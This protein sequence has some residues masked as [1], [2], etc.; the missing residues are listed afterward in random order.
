MMLEKSV[1][2]ELNIDRCISI[3]IGRCDLRSVCRYVSRHK[4]TCC[5]ICLHVVCYMHTDTSTIRW[6]NVDE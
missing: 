4:L 2:N 5:H 3:D 6:K 1:C